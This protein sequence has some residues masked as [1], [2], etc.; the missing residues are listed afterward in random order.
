MTKPTTAFLTKVAVA[1]VTAV[2]IG[3]GTAIMDAQATNSV[4]N[5]RLDQLE[6]TGQRMDALSDKLDVTNQNVA[7][8]NAVLQERGRDEA[9]H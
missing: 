5:Q 4:Q 3:G 1:L 7:A 6:K 9:S 2:L 8:L